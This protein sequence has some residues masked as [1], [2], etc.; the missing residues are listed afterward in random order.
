MFL[1]LF[2]PYFG[3]LR[4]TPTWR[5][6]ANKQFYKSEWE[7]SYNNTDYKTPTDLNLDKLVYISI[8]NHI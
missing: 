3:F 6:N 4:W 5:L 8:T 1:L 2:S 7:I